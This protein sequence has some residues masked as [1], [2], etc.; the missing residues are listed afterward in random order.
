M[1][2]E[3]TTTYLE[4]T[5]PE[6]L[7]PAR[8]KPARGNVVI[9]Q[10]P[11]PFP[12][13]NRFFYAT[14]GGDWYW[15]DRLPWSYAQWM[16]YLDRPELKTWIVTVDGV[17][18]GYCELDKQAD[19]SVEVAYFGILRQFTGQGLGGMLLTAGVRRAWE[20]GAK[21]VWVHTCTLDDPRALSHYEARGFRIYKKETETK[22]LADRPPGPW[23]TAGEM[24]ARG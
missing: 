5:S 2:H 3:L 6:Q 22:Q 4:M 15:T 9:S 16:K 7:S 21:R 17:P 8:S 23:P 12:E 14:I 1:I 19:G 13:L 18:A 10:V 20:M 11:H 24:A